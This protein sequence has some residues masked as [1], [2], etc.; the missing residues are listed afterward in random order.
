MNQLNKILKSQE[1][2]YRKMLDWINDI[3]SKEVG[4]ALEIHT[5]PYGLSYFNRIKNPK[6]HQIERKYIPKNDMKQVKIIANKQFYR[7]IQKEILI[8]YELIKNLN[9]LLSKPLIEDKFEKLHPNRKAL[10]E[11]IELTYEEKLERWKSQSYI[12]N[13]YKIEE[14]TIR[15][16][17]D[18]LVRSK[19]EKIMADKFYE[20]GIEYKYECPLYL[21][22]GKTIYPDFTFLSPR[23]GKEIYW[24][25]FGIMDDSEYAD[26]SIRKIISYHD[27]DIFLG[28]NLICTF[29]SKKSPLDYKYVEFLVRKYLL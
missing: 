1:L 20:F 8:R 13:Q 16:N 17:K 4:G 24:E 6:T 23:T 26:N 19:S 12:S 7:P 9:E 11:K 22:N 3:C 21:E 2:K 18:E 28:E 10:I 27:N 5:R 15:T 25:H 29:E 14:A